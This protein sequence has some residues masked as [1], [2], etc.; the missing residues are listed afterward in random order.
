M[1][2]MLAMILVVWGA[3]LVLIGLVGV[4]TKDEFMPGRILADFVCGPAF[5]F[6]GFVVDRRKPKPPA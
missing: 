1:I 4:A 6:V 5:V 2:R 3:G